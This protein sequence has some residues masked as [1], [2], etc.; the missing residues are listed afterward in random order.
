LTLSPL[1]WLARRFCISRRWHHPELKTF[2]ERISVPIALSCKSHFIAAIASVSLAM[3]NASGHADAFPSRNITFTPNVVEGTVT[4]VDGR[5][6]PG[7]TIRISG[8]TGAARGTTIRAKTDASGRYRVTVPLGHYN[9]D[10]FAD[11][12]YSGQTYKEI[13]LDRGNAPC[14]RVMSDKGIVRNF[15][16]RL[17]GPKRCTNQRDP[18]NPDS[19]NG[20]Y[21]TAMTSAFPDD[22]VISFKLTPLGPLADG[23]NGRP[24][25]I[26]RTGAALKKGGG[27]IE[28]TAFLHD[29]P[30]GRYRVAAEVRYADGR[31]GGTTLEL[32][33]GGNTSGNTLDVAFNANVFGG[34]IRPIGIGLTA[35]GRAT[36]S[37]PSTP[38]AQ[39]EPEP[40]TKPV[41]ATPA[42]PQTGSSGA[43]LPVGR[44]S[45]SYRSPYAGDIPTE[46]SITIMA[47]G[48]YQGYGRSGTFKFDFGTGTVKWTGPLGEG[49]VRATFGKRNGQPAITVVGGGASDDPE[50]TNYCVLTGS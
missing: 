10:G 36:A 26:T 32:R 9:V 44:Y 34:G 17:S 3:P 37:A 19:Y 47:G 35:G 18:N 4:T 20:A 30:L 41:P 43:E 25:T 27:P 49:D 21:I 11:I 24:L 45:C 48:R 2:S 8:A 29:I 40:P 50:R 15:T 22:A 14:E 5:P 31:T 1:S 46:K 7:A 33:D 13:W 42:S 38:E 16:L 28:E 6:L 23:S 39:P 12:E